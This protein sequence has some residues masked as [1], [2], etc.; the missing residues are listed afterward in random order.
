LRR[1][2]RT[3]LQCNK[4][5]PSRVCNSLISLGFLPLTNRA[6]C[7][8]QGGCLGNCQAA[9]QSINLQSNQPL[10]RVC[11]R[12]ASSRGTLC[13]CATE[14]LDPGEIRNRVARSEANTQPWRL[15]HESRPS[16]GVAYLSKLRNGVA[17][18]GGKTHQKIA[19]SC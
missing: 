17:R 19:Q 2:A 18:I 5:C 15:T 14:L 13:A 1:S 12:H 16:N 4:I 10:A 9:C 8:F 3:V 11:K 6:A 7:A